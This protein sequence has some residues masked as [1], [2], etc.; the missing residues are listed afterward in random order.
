MPNLRITAHLSNGFAAFDD[1]SPDLAGLLEWQLLDGY[2]LT[3]PNPTA[4]DVETS[5]PLVEAEMPLQRAEIGGEWYWACSSPCYSYATETTDKFRKRWAPGI[6]SPEPNWGKRKATWNNSAG[7]EKSY[8]LPL[9]LRVT[10]ALTWYAVGDKAGIETLLQRCTG[11]GKKRAHGHGQVTHWEVNEIE[12]DWHL[13][14]PNGEL[15]RPIPITAVPATPIDFAIRDWGWRPPAWLPTNKTRC[16]M[17]V[18]NARQVD[19]NHLA[20]VGR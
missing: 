14:G 19:R 9:Y 7:G 20:S 6:D 13:F 15:M 5:R 1:W 16:A 12:H 3:A 2:G 8:D 4:A 18:H 10:D 17:P 11:V